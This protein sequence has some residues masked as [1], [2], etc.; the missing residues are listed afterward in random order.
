MNQRGRADKE[1]WCSDAKE[2]AQ[3]EADKD[4]QAGPSL[5]IE[6]RKKAAVADIK[7]EVATLSLE[8]AEKKVIKGHFSDKPS[9]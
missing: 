9:N 4:D 2:L 6:S 1:K 8:I 3:A 7:N 5:P